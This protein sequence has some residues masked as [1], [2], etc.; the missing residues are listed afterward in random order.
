MTTAIAFSSS[1]ARF[2]LPLLYTAQA[3]KEVCV[4]EAFSIID[5]MLGCAIEGVAAA[6]PATPTEG[7]NWLVATGATGAWAGTD[8]QIA[9]FQ[10]GNWIFVAPRD[11]IVVLNRGSGQFMHYAGGWRQP[12]APAIPAGG[13]T[14]DSEAR[15]SIAALIAALIS[16]GMFPTG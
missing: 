2:A 14:I 16:A 8:G 13:A 11:G 15:D 9:A 5:A 4:N 6:P 3:Q 1:S 7:T 10:G 12:T